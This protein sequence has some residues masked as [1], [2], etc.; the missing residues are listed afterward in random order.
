MQLA[1]GFALGVLASAAVLI[2]FLCLQP[3]KGSSAPR[4]LPLSD[5]DSEIMTIRAALQAQIDRLAALPANIQ[6][7]TAS[8]VNAALAADATSRAADEAEGDAALTTAI[9]TV[10]AAAPAPA[11][12]QSD[13]QG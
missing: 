11:A 12:T 3:R 8:A 1:A 13:A 7:N 6:A 5:V 9:D 2:A 10:V 4:V